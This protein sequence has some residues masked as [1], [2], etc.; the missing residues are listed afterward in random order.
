[1]IELGCY[2]RKVINQEEALKTTLSFT[3]PHLLLSLKVRRNRS[4]F[5]GMLLRLGLGPTPEQVHGTVTDAVLQP[6]SMWF[7]SGLCSS[8][9][10]HQLGRRPSGRVRSFW[11]LIHKTVFTPSSGPSVLSGCVC[12]TWAFQRRLRT[13]PCVE[14][15]GI[16]LAT[17]TQT[18]PVLRKSSTE[19]PILKLILTCHFLK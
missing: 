4:L 3:V 1:M 7:G 18:W 13:C 2:I 16:Y 5:E 12:C 10:M 19:C 14:V 17:T 15:A 9:V 8:Q 6:S 11:P